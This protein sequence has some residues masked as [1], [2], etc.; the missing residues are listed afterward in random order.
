MSLTRFLLHVGYPQQATGVAMAVHA[1]GDFGAPRHVA[2]RNRI[3]PVC[4]KS[5][6]RCPRRER[7]GTGLFDVP[8]VLHCGLLGGAV[9]A[10][11]KVFCLRQGLEES[12]LDRATR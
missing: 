11:A 4:L 12:A 5:Q 8:A 7:A 6:R 9:A 3:R 10:G 2:G 1:A